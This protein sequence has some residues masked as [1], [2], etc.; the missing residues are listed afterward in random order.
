[1]HCIKQLKIYKCVSKKREN[2]IEIL[3]FEEDEYIY[4]I[5]FL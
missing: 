5:E 3:N 2:I 1:M 4:V